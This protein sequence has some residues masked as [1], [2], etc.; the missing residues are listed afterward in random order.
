MAFFWRYQA[1]K[2]RQAVV[3]L[4]RTRKALASRQKA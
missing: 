1:K 4:E 2:L 3:Y